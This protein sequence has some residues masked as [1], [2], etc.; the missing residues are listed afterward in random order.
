MSFSVSMSKK[1]KGDIVEVSHEGGKGTARDWDWTSF[2]V[3][4]PDWRHGE[5]L[6]NFP[7]IQFQSKRRP[8]DT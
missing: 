5:L 6:A 1:N 3:V 7:F 8:L 4:Q 2:I